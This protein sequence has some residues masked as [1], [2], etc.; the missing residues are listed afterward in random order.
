MHFYTFLT[1]L[2]VLFAV[3]RNQVPCNQLTLLRQFWSIWIKA[4]ILTNAEKIG[5][6]PR[7]QRSQINTSVET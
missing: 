1:F 6:S 7:V 3:D 2:S 4:D 5:N